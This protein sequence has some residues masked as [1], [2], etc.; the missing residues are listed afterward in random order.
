MGLFR[1]LARNICAAGPE[2]Y[3]WDLASLRV[4]AFSFHGF[5][6]LEIRLILISL[7][8]RVWVA[9]P[10]SSLQQGDEASGTRKS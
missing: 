1:L 5:G 6:C 7:G 8:G 9:G 2:E 4:R 3:S 10:A